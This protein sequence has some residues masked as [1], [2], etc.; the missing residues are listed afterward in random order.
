VLLAVG[1][2]VILSLE[3]PTAKVALEFV[4][5]AVRPPMTSESGGIVER[6][7]AERGLA[8]KGTFIVVS[9]HVPLI[10]VAG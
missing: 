5:G 10:T 7:A 2:Q 6:F 8:H 4:L 1:V 3:S 9:T